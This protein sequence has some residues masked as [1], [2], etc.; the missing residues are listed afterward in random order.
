VL[1]VKQN[2]PK[3]KVNPNAKGGKFYEGNFIYRR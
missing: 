3:F 2:F 1:V